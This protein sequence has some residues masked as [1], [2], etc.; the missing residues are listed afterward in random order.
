MPWTAARVAV[1][2]AMVAVLVLATGCGSGDRVTDPSDGA[3]AAGDA[4]PTAEELDGTTFLS[5]EVTGHDLVE[6][7]RVRLAFEGDRLSANAGCNHQSATY[8]IDDGRLQW[9]GAAMSTEM[10]CEADLQAQDEWLASLLEEGAAIAGD[11][12]EITLTGGAVTLVLSGASAADLTSLLGTTWT[13]TTL[14]DSETETASSLP[15]GVRTPTLIVGEDGAATLDTGCNRGDTEVSV[16]GSSVRFAPVRTTLMACPGD[17]GEVEQSVLLV[18]DGT[19]DDVAWDG[20][21]LT[22]TRGTTGLG[23]TV[24]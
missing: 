5:T 16:A 20:E 24:R 19:V 3:R 15:S 7:T 1:M 13:L 12:S 10:G 14:I 9:T 23:F 17:A 4:A 22:L 6:G 11:A 21:S 2:S 8:A 18:L